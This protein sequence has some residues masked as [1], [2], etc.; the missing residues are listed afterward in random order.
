[1]LFVGETVDLVHDLFVVHGNSFSM[2]RNLRDM[3]TGT[4]LAQ[5]L[6]QA[7]VGERFAPGLARGA[8]LQRLGGER[9][10]AYDVAALR[11]GFAGAAVHAHGPLLVALEL[12][13]LLPAGALHG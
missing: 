10:L 8:V 12:G 5:E 2:G 7:P 9:H 13:S 1:M 4:S 11:A 3:D 6:R